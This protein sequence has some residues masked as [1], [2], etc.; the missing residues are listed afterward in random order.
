MVTGGQCSSAVYGSDATET[1][2]VTT[3]VRLRKTQLQKRQ[4]SLR[5]R[6]LGRHRGKKG[7]GNRAS[8]VEGDAATTTANGVGAVTGGVMRGWQRGGD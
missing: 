7:K 3:I 4:R 1:A 8:A 5:Q 6:G 2:K